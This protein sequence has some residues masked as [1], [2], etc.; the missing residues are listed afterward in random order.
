[1]EIM[2][3]IVNMTMDILTKNIIVRFFNALIFYL[4]IYI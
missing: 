4:S 1:M 2:K 3:N